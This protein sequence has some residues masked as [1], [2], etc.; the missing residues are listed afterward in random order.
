M[1]ENSTLKIN[2]D[3][4]VPRRI[5]LLWPKPDTR[6]PEAHR[7]KPQLD[8]FVDCEYQ[9]FSNDELEAQDAA[10]EAG[11]LD[12][13]DRFHMLVPV[14]NGLPLKDGQSPREFL[15]TF[16]YGAVIRAA[17]NADYFEFIGEGRRGNSGKRR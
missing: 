2:V 15:D 7:P 9:Y 12:R 16:K 10:I 6:V 14:I 4:T 3:T 17:I 8:G 1:S 13:I 11:E 5:P